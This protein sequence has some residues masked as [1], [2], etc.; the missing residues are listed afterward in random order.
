M[1]SDISTS[2]KNINHYE[3]IIVGG[4][5][6]GAGIFRDLALHGIDCLLLDKGDFSAQTSQKSSKMLHGGIRYLE[7]MDFKLVF[8]ALAEKNLWLKIAPHLAQENPLTLPVYKS[9]KRPLWMIHAGLF[10]YDLLSQ[11]K[12]SPFKILDQNQTLKLCPHLNPEE[13]IGSGV[14]YDGVMDD[15]KITLEVIYDALL[16]SNASAIN[17][18]EVFDIKTQDD[19]S[20]VYTKNLINNSLQVYSCD[21]IVFALGPYTDIFLKKFSQFNWQDVLIPSKG[22]HLWI[23]KKDLPLESPIVITTKDNRVIFVI[24]H[25]DKILVGTTEIANDQNLDQLSPTQAEIDYLLLAL[26][27]YFP[28][29]SIDKDKILSSFSGV[30]PLIQEENSDR[31]TTSREHKIYQPTAN[32]YVIAGGKYTTFRVMGQDISKEIC[33]KHGRSYICDKTTMPLRQKSIIL[34]FEWRIPSEIDL[35][36]ICKNELPMTF[37]DLVVRRLGIASRKIW[38]V[39]NPTVDFNQFFISYINLFNTY[40]PI[41]KEDIINFS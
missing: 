35:E 23:S 6:V 10:L 22:S 26:E 8:E 11:F 32:T 13:L 21:Q 7:N 15:V 19:K 24:P 5:I 25:G 17:Y 14:Y 34:P 4:G 38:Q 39:K 40:F 16:Q 20:I 28:K 3:T 12:N 36:N 18:S 31:G 9:S 33:H 2:Q 1:Y 30:R 41:K 29:L 27:K 37:E